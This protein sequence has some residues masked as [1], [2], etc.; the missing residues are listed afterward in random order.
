M[1]TKEKINKMKEDSSKKTKNMQNFQKIK[2]ENS[3][4]VNYK[5]Q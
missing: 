1:K 2:I 5:Y 3:E 4:D